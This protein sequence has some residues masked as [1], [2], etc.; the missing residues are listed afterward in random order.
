VTAMK[1]A[2]VDVV[3]YGGTTPGAK[4]V[5]QLRDGG[6]TDAAFVSGD[7]SLDQGFIDN[8]GDAAEGAVLGSPAPARPATGRRNIQLHQPNPST[9]GLFAAPA[10]R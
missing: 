4:L 6:V 9:S 10:Q 3:F 5:T 7:G 2:G 8:A 1:D